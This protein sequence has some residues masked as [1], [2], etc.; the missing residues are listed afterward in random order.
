MPL[1]HMS[2]ILL[3]RQKEMHTKK[4]FSIRELNINKN[5]RSLQTKYMLE[6]ESGIS[7]VCIGLLQLDS[8]INRR[9]G[10]FSQYLVYC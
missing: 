9:Q 2:Q 7:A 10:K 5:P 4:S 3:F 1:S 8:Q 6:I